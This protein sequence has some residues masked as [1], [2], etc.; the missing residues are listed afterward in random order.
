MNSPIAIVIPWVDEKDPKWMKSKAKYQDCEG[1]EASNI[2]FQ[3]WDNKHLWFRAIESCMSWVNR[4]FLI[5]C[6]HVPTFLNIE[7][8]GIRLVRH[9][10]YIPEEYLPTFNSNTI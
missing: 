10:E 7:E 9:D 1:F 2:R 3:C 6:G 8:S 5:T 4:I